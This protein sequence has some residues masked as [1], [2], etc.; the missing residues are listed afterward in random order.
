M[1]SSNVVGT[2][3]FKPDLAQVEIDILQPAYGQMLLIS[4]TTDSFNKPGIILGNIELMNPEGDINCFPISHVWGYVDENLRFSGRYTTDRNLGWTMQQNKTYSDHLY[5]TIHSLMKDRNKIKIWLD[6]VCS[7]QQDIGLYQDVFRSMAIIYGQCGK[8]VSIPGLNSNFNKYN[9]SQL[10]SLNSFAILSSNLVESEKALLDYKYGITNPKEFFDESFALQV[11][12]ILLSMNITGTN[13]SFLT[14]EDAWKKVSYMPYR[15]MRDVLLILG[16]CKRIFESRYFLRV[17]TFQEMMLPDEICFSMSINGG[18]NDFIESDSLFSLFTSAVKVYHMIADIKDVEWKYF[19]AFDLYRLTAN[20]AINE[21][22]STWRWF[23]RG[24]ELAKRFKNNNVLNQL[25]GQGHSIDVSYVEEL[26]EIY[27]AIPRKCSF[28]QDYVHGIKGLI[29]VDCK[30]SGDNHIVAVNELFQK[31]GESTGRCWSTDGFIKQNDGR[32]DS[33]RSFIPADVPNSLFLRGFRHVGSREISGNSNDNSEM[34]LN[35]AIATGGVWMGRS[36][37]VRT[38]KLDRNNTPYRFKYSPCYKHSVHRAGIR[39]PSF[40]TG[41][42]LTSFMKSMLSRL[43]LADSNLKK[44]ILKL[45]NLEE[46]IDIIHTTSLRHEV[47]HQIETRID[48]KSKITDL[49]PEVGNGIEMF[50][51]EQDLR[52]VLGLN[53]QQC[54]LLVEYTCKCGCT[55]LMPYAMSENLIKYWF[56]RNDELNLCAMSPEIDVLEIRTCTIPVSKKISYKF[57]SWIDRLENEIGFDP[58]TRKQT[59]AD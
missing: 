36:L 48:E 6:F 57:V 1:Q 34:C 55:F 37:C 39:P 11:R 23:K 30:Y 12:S 32:K 31:L 9:D 46:G 21:I 24:R 2:V 15:C 13:I 8:C 7:P 28:K 18:A 56:G 43:G 20:T 52:D 58:W 51:S 17:W 59:N 29:P 26:F 38:L 50:C 47:F 44:S 42:G 19:A 35:M 53:E 45:G 3:I 49:P 54:K 5:N 41:I 16:V 25:R 10:K 40:L 4:L 33:W 14:S 22:E 27:T